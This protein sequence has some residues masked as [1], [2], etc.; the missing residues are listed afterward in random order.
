MRFP[1]SGFEC[2]VKESLW[3][4]FFYHYDFRPVGTCRQRPG[5][6][7]VLKAVFTYNQ[8]ADRLESRRVH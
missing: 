7:L 2:D 5:D 6:D 4:N 8:P 3:L 1:S